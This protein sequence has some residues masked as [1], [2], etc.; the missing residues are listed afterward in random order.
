V[1]NKVSAATQKGAEFSD[2]IQI[3]LGEIALW[4]EISAEA[5]HALIRGVLL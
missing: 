3:A 1:S 4:G 2:V 5:N